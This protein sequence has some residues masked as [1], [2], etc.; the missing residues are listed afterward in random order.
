MEYKYRIIVLLAQKQLQTGLGIRTVREQASRA[1]R[2]SYSQF[3]R[4]ARLPSN[5]TEAF[6]DTALYALSHYFRVDIDELF[7]NTNY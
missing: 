5:S 1:S 6:T 3:N 7:N 4:L 2:L